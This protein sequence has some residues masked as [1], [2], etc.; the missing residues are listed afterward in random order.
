MQMIVFAGFLIRP[1]VAFRQS[2]QIY[3]KDDKA[4]TT[5]R[6]QFQLKIN[7]LKLNF[8]ITLQTAMFGKNDL[9]RLC[10]ESDFMQHLQRRN[11]H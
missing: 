8:K 5:S 11:K 1:V 4:K 10:Y 3:R 7:K 2:R 6:S 9:V